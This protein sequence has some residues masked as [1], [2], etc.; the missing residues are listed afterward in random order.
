M[1]RVTNFRLGSIA[2]VLL[3]LATSLLNPP[4]ARAQEDAAGAPASYMLELA[5]PPAAAVYAGLTSGD[6]V[7]AAA[8]TAA[9]QRHLAAIDAAQQA[10]T[11]LLAQHGVPVLYRTQRVYNGIAVRARPEQIAE[12]A[13]LPG[14]AAIRRIIP[15][16]PDNATSVPYLDAPLLWEGLDGATPARG[17]G[18]RIAVIDTGIDYL[19]ADFGGPATGAAYAANDPTVIGDVPGFPGI[20]IAGGYDFAGDRYNA[21]PDARA[22]NPIPQPDPDPMDCYG[23]GTHV[24]GTAAGFGVTGDSAAYNGPYSASANLGALRIGPGVAPLAELYA[25]KI[26]G[27]AGSSDLVPLAMEW[28]VD[29]DGDGDF[30]DRVDVIN[31][32]LGS[33]YGELYDPTTIAADNA[34]Q[35]GV[36]VVASAGNSGDDFFVVG[37]PSNADRS[38]SVAAIQHGQVTLADGEMQRV[39]YAAGFSSRGPRAGD[40]GLKPDLA[41][42]GVGIVSASSLS[43]SGARTLSGT[44]MAAPHVA[45]VMALLRELHPDWT[46]EELKA[47]AMNTAY[48]LV[49]AG[50]E[51][52]ST[53]YAPGRVGAGRIDPLM[54]VKSDSVAYNAQ[55][56]GRVSLPFGALDVL[57]SFTAAQNVRIA[58]KGT[59]TRTFEASYYAV[60]DLAGVTVTVPAAPIVLPAA[61]QSDIPVLLAVNAGELRRQPDPAL[62]VYPVYGRH[63]LDE[64][65]GHVLLWPQG[66]NWQATFT[67]DSAVPAATSGASGSAAFGYSPAA[68]QLAYTVTIT[69][70]APAGVLTIT[71]GAGRPGDELAPLYTLYSAADGP[72]PATISGTVTF[73]PAHELLLAAGG[74]AVNVATAAWPAGEVRGQLD[75]QT[76]VLHLPLHAAP[77][78]VS[79]MH[80]DRQRIDFGSDAATTPTFALT[81]QPLAPGTAPTPTVALASLFQLEW[82]SANT[83]PPGLPDKVPDTFD[84]ADISHVG[85]A[86]DL[87]SESF[88]SAMLYFA[89]ATHAPW[90]SPNTVRFDIYLDVNGDGIDDYRLFNSNRDGYLNE[91]LGSDSFVAAL[92]NLRT[93]M[94][95]ALE[96]INALPV[97]EG[98]SRPYLSRVLVLP[99]RVEALQL[100]PMQ[101]TIAYRIESY[102]LYLGDQPAQIIDELGTRHLD[103]AH[104]ALDL[105]D[106]KAGAPTVA[107]QPGRT[108]SA[109]LDLLGYG[110]AR[111]GGVLILHHHNAPEAQ[112]DVVALDYRWPATLYLP[113]LVR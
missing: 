79:A 17:E 108:F 7:N 57:D 25:L 103:L 77:R 51:L 65:S 22:Y 97:A 87:P 45:G 102:H 2:A 84:S 100:P 64:E 93:G 4:A 55:V 56:P 112:V 44:S 91:F 28:A 90:S 80:A 50:Q 29:P 83:R 48:P 5:A 19:H 11:A 32:S 16:Q 53:L 8:A 23:H 41:A 24:A 15:A 75:V 99:V 35:L 72:L 49:R 14:V 95:L 78:A 10:T 27:C 33:P 82:Q 70:I 21:D 46:V 12:L 107:D 37:S 31:L 76:P 18:M 74:L 101:T 3:L 92:K 66:T 67:G 68:A 71:L 89:I 86:T 47:L 106:G 54:A 39:E 60:T 110:T 58:N 13:A 94:V 69:D 9:T 61:T 98:D 30:A 6:Q 113:Q 1:S 81:G 111:P 85:I 52:T 20:K 59:M 63:W 42:P 88:A 36:I 43:G 104:P 109:E 73:D 26:F 62:G 105:L 96:P 34:A 40:A 38:I